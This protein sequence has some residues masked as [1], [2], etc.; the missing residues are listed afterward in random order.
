D[1]GGAGGLGFKGNGGG[2]GGKSLGIGGIGNGSGRGTGGLG[3]V[4]LGGKGRAK[5]KVT[6]GRTVTK[7]CLS[8]Q[9]V[10]RVISRSNSRVRFCYE[11]GLQRNPNL[12]GKV[13]AAWI[14]GPTG[15]VLRAN[16]SQ[17]T[18][19]DATVEQCI[20]RVVQQMKFPPCAGGGTADVTYPW[21]FKPSGG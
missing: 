7:G 2:G 20:V 8:Q 10:G 12:A 19:G 15:S 18:M 21:L 6:P 3:D 5:F 1:A 9:V 14:V 16:I 4:D 17:S 13:T 11:K